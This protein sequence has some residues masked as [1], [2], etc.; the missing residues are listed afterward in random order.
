[1]TLEQTVRDFCRE[2]DFPLRKEERVLC[3]V[4]GGTDSMALLHY[5]WKQGCRVTAATFDHGIRPTSGEDVAFVQNWCREREIPCV[6]GRGDVPREA[7]Q[8]G[9]TLEEAA[10]RLRYAFLERAAREQGISCIATAHNADDQAE[11]VL[12]RLLRGTGLKGLGGIPPRRGNIIRPLLAVTRE[13]IEA[14]CAKN[15]I[16][17]RED[18]TNSDTAYTRNFIRHEIMPRLKEKNPDLPHTLCRTAESLR[19]DNRFLEQ[20]AEQAAQGLLRREGNEIS[21]PVKE[22]LALPEPVGLRLVGRMSCMLDDEVILSHDQ[23]RALLELAKSQDP[24]GKISLPFRL[25]GRRV[26]G[27]L[28]LSRFQRLGGAF[29]PVLLRPGECRALPELEGAVF[30]REAIC[31]EQQ[32]KK[33]VYLK[34]GW[35]ALTIRPRRDGDRF[36][37][38]GRP[39]KRLKKLFMEA[40]IPREK[41]DRVPVL[42]INGEIAA[43]AGFGASSQYQALPG[44]RSWQI[45]ISYEKEKEVTL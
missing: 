17:H 28:I 16:D 11:T 6:T 14:Y 15:A 9:Q 27:M 26:Y 4:S 41:R 36:Q 42:E 39:L 33:T 45:T 43:V 23:R 29:A 5:L 20:A 12:L 38:P 37:Q 22:L 2:N 40:R 19:Q 8:S 10:R 25:Q 31:P 24:G 18:E 32:E 1:M 35:D 3:A 30:C 7:K 21:V 34:Q 13:E 44:E